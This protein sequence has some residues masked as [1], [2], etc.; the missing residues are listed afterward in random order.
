VAAAANALAGKLNETE[1]IVARLRER[2]PGLRISRI[3]E[4][5]GP[6]PP[7]AAPRSTVHYPSEI[8][9][10]DNRLHLR[11]AAR[12]ASSSCD[13]A[14]NPDGVSRSCF[15]CPMS[16]THP[17]PATHLLVLRNK[18]DAAFSQD[19]TACTWTRP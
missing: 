6:Y 8:L 18:I 11:V 19:R 1:K 5:L 10:H 2:D 3:R 12:C 17:V 15:P 7:E 13:M 14:S 16:S 4:A 9:P